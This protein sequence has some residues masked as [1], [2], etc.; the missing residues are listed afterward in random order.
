MGGWYAPYQSEEKI[1]A[2][3]ADIQKLKKRNNRRYHN[4]NDSNLKKTR[5]KYSREKPTW[6]KKNIN[7][8]DS[9]SKIMT[10]NET[11]WN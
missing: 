2:L 6:M 9:E 11:A 8:D 5:G 10:W 4:V 3:Q 1:L 7:P